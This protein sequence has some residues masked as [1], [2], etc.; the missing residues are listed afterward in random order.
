MEEDKAKES[1][2]GK[3]WKRQKRRGW[4][5]LRSREEGKVGKGK[6][7]GRRGGDKRK[8]VKRKEEG[9]RGKGKR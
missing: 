9:R 7:E 4:K 6:E 8:R 5:R 2:V 3:R 1:R